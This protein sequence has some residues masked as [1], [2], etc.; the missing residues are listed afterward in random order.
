ME[1]RIGVAS[2]TKI[3]WVRNADG[4]RGDTWN[5]VTGCTRVSA[6]CDRCYA[7]VMTHRL[8]AM[9]QTAKYGGL[10]VLNAKGERHFNGVVRCHEDALPIPLKRKKPTTWFVNSMSDLFHRDVPFDF[11]L[12]VWDVM[13]SATRNCR[14]RGIEQCDTECWRGPPHTF[15]VLTKRPEIAFDVL[16][17]LVAAA[18]E[19][20]PGDWPLANAPWPLPNVWLGVSVENQAAADVRREHFR[21]CL[22]SVRFVSYEPALG[23]VD[24]TGWEFVDQIISGGESGP[25][26][27]PSHPDWH[28]A[29]RD[30]CAKN[31]IAYFFK[32][33]GGR[34]KKAA[35][36]LLDG[37]EW[38][39]MPKTVTL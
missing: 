32:Q 8:E 6:G 21:R 37:R 28:R 14:H 5:C 1:R 34:N 38:N 15:Q 20:V 27:R 30:W 22:A 25:G 33:A 13:A 26:A 9:G 10:T 17:K 7:V 29:T 12:R 2:G 36:R 23:P 18:G 31:G 4:S 19:R 35:G 24:W 16:E 39:E 11:I 3:E